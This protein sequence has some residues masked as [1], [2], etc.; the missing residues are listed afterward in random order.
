MQRFIQNLQSTTHGTHPGHLSQTNKK[1]RK[2]QI[3]LQNIQHF[4]NMTVHI[5]ETTLSN[6]GWLRQSKWQSLTS[7]HLLQM[8]GMKSIQKYAKMLF[9]L[10]TTN[11]LPNQGNVKQQQK[12]TNKLCH[13][14]DNVSFVVILQKHFPPQ[15][16]CSGLWAEPLPR[17]FGNLQER[18]SELSQPF[19]VSASMDK[20]ST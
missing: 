10:L 9:T 11:Y 15:P 3:F 6:E 4:L 19:P 5:N 8:V 13:S 7:Q 16:V 2:R 14:W 1:H 17:H 12:K 18:E 20:A